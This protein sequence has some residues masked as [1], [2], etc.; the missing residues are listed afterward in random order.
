[1]HR[2][3]RQTWGRRGSCLVS[4]FP[5]FLH[6]ILSE[7]IIAVEMRLRIRCLYI[8]CNVGVSIVCLARHISL[9]CVCGWLYLFICCNVGVSSSLCLAR[10]IS[11]YSY[12]GCDV[13]VSTVCGWLYLFI[14]CN[15]GVSSSM[16]LARQISLYSYIGCNMSLYK[17]CGWLY[18][19]RGC[20][21]V[22]LQ[23]VSGRT[24]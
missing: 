17:V 12:I 22:C 5:L 9:Y 6:T 18:V 15:V 11:L 1:M 24:D 16:C 2:F 14:C 19:Y 20:N 8:G 3:T 21:V 7:L 10:Q 4:I 13:G 23:C